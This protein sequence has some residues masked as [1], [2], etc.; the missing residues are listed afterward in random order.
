[1]L[2]IHVRQVLAYLSL[3]TATKETD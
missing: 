3:L 2:E 1:M